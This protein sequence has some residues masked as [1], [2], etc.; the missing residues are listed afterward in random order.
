MGVV[1]D[2]QPEVFYRYLVN[3]A[4]YLLLRLPLSLDPEDLVHEAWVGAMR[5]HPESG[6]W[7]SGTYLKRWIYG[8]AMRQSRLQARRVFHS[9]DAPLLDGRSS[10]GQVTAGSKNTE[11]EAIVNV[12]LE[13]TY[14]LAKSDPDIVLL[15]R[16]VGGD[17]YEEM[18]ERLGYSKT[19]LASA[20]HKGRQRLLGTRPER[21]RASR[22]QVRVVP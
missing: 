1:G 14:E 18:G 11:H 5:S 9:F 4:R 12:L 8:V 15:L 17:T 7:F 16:V 21:S 22:R 2:F 19:E 20:T 6:P 3:Y 10:L 13:W